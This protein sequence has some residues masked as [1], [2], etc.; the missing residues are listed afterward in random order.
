MMLES[1]WR[2]KHAP[3]DPRSSCDVS[4]KWIDVEDVVPIGSTDYLRHDTGDVVV[5]KSQDFLNHLPGARLTMGKT[6]SFS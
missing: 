6:N 3:R 2:D 4:E 5:L 1:W